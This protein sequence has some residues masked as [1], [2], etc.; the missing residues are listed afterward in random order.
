[1]PGSDAQ[2]E[3][4]RSEERELSGKFIVGLVSSYDIFKQWVTCGEALSASKLQRNHPNGKGH[5]MI[6]G[7]IVKFFK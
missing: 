4:Y 1:M 7:E 5:L 2:L 3:E 6:T